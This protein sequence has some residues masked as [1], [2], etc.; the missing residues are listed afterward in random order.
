M[1]DTTAIIE[2]NQ[3]IAPG[4]RLLTLAFDRPVRA[5]SGQFA[6]L[7]AHAVK[8]SL[9]NALPKVVGKPLVLTPAQIQQDQ[10]YLAQHWSAAIGG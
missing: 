6:M 5:R 7:K 10:A 4:Y 8:A 2:N 9:V 3:E 1:I